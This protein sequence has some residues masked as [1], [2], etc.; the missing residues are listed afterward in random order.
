MSFKRRPPERVSPRVRQAVRNRKSI[1]N[2]G[3]ALAA[4]PARTVNELDQSQSVEPDLVSENYKTAALNQKANDFA[5]LEQTRQVSSADTWGKVL[6]VLIAGIWA[7]GAVFGFQIALS[8][9]VAVGLIIAVL[10][11]ASPAL[12]LLSIGILSTADAIA[13]NYLLTGGLLRFNTVNY[14]LLVVIALHIPFILRLRDFPARAL[15]VFLILIALEISFSRDISEGVQDVLNIG[16]TFGLI[17]YFARGLKDERALYWLGVING[18]LGSL[19]GLVYFLQIT[20]LPYANPNN[21]TYVQLTALFS[22]CISLPYA[23]AFRKSKL[24]LISLAVLNLAWVFLSGSRGGMLIAS[25]CVLYLFF[26]TRSVKGSTAMLAIAAIV[27][28]WVSNQ[29]V[30]QQLFS[31]NRIRLLF[32]TTESESRRTSNRSDIAK[33]GWELFKDHPLGIG[34]GS[35]RRVANQTGLVGE[36]RPAHSAWIKTLAEN[37]VPGFLLLIMFVGSFTLVGLHKR[38]EG[39]FML[40]LFITLVLSVAFISH[41][42]GGKSL[43]F[44]TAAGIV[45]LH[46]K[47]VSGFIHK[48]FRPAAAGYQQRLREVRFGRRR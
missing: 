12:G 21:W 33:A 30:E 5:Y 8:I 6:F 40:G 37:G 11:L 39:K 25:L 47:E 28:L 29:F 17:V 23:H 7:A 15:Q 32:D 20:E 31:I 27:F 36:N 43:W 26:A 2:T 38:Q 19:I 1:P 45:L 41:E 13:A 16:A 46:P 9:Q 35:F 18:L 10:G 44:L 4:Q 48:K 34:T 24:L 3:L 14:W 22:I 42:F